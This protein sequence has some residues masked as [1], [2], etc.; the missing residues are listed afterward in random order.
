MKQIH[1]SFY[2]FLLFCELAISK[3]SAS[4][5]S[6]LASASA[7]RALTARSLND[8]FLSSISSLSISSFGIS[9][10]SVSS[11]LFFDNF[12]SVKGSFLFDDGLTDEDGWSL[13]KSITVSLVFWLRDP[14]YI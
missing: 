11:L 10:F 9:S 13:V 14:M 5:S 6:F 7:I 4:A 1:D 3:A 8:I 12:L 2:S